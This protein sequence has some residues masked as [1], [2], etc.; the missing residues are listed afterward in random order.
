MGGVN[1]FSTM[2][3]LREL[4]LRDQPLHCMAN[5]Y[6]PIAFGSPLN[7]KPSGVRGSQGLR[8]LV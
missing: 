1:L 7:L 5:P 3:K 8:E 2:M 6:H 4:Q